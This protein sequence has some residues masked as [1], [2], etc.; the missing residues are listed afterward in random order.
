V[1][2]TEGRAFMALHNHDHDA[3]PNYCYVHAFGQ[4]DPI[5]LAR[6]LR[7][8]LNRTNSARGDA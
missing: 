3:H 2:P 5:K 1:L 8:A 7:R 6:Q 4:D